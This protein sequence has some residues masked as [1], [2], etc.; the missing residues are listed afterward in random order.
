MLSLSHSELIILACYLRCSHRNSPPILSLLYAVRIKKNIYS[1]VWDTCLWMIEDC[2][3]FTDLNILSSNASYVYSVRILSYC[4]LWF[5]NYCTE[6][7]QRNRN[8]GIVFLQM[9]ASILRAFLYE[10]ILQYIIVQII[11]I[12]KKR[13]TVHSYFHYRR[14]L[15]II[16]FELFLNMNS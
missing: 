14:W 11:S 3:I 13:I 2:K 16:D 15:W 6:Y 9:L 4:S 8:F 10:Y 12:G 1:Y 5:S 7:Y